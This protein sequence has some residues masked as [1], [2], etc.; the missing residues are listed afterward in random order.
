MPAAWPR[1]AC[2][3]LAAILAVLIFHQ[4]MWAVLHAAKL[5]PPPFPTARV[6]PFGLP[7]IVDLCFWGGVWG[8]L[9]GLV[10]PVLP[11][12]M[13]M[14]LLGLGLGILAALVGLFVVAPLKG[15]PPA[16]GFAPMAFVISF[17]INGFWGFGVGLILNLTAP[18]VRHP[19]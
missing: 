8:A 19:A 2:G 10:L 6:G 17:L 5:M 13:P 14:W 16:G 9:F 18:F 3:F 11:E 12:R 1:A 4:A 7:R 15:L